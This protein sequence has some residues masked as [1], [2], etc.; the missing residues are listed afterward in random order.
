MN[1]RYTK[2]HVVSMSK[3]RTR[4]EG[5]ILLKSKILMYKFFLNNDMK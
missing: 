2:T 4:Q 3:F 1:K 5:R